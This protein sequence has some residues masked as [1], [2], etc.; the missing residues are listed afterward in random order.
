MSIISLL[1][2]VRNNEVV[3]PAIQ[4]DFVWEKPKIQKLLDSIFRGYPVGIALLWET[5]HELQYR[6]F[7][8]NYRSETLATFKDN[9]AGKRIRVV[10]DGQQRLQSLF[11][12]LFG[13]FDGEELWFDMLSGRS[14][15]DVSESKFLF[16][17]CSKPQAAEWNKMTEEFYTR[18]AEERDKDFL[19]WYYIKI[20][21]LYAMS[22]QA[23]EKL[24]SKTIKD[25]PLEEDDQTRSR[26]NLAT[27][28]QMLTK[29]ENVL[30]L[31]IID[32]NL[33]PESPDRKTE[34][35]VLEIF[36]RINREGT[37]LNRAD[38]IF[39]MLKLNWKESAE[40]LPEFVLKI[41][42]GNSLGLNADFV[43]RC[44]FAVSDLGAKFDL[45]LLRKKANVQK[46]RENFE[47]C[48]NAIRVT[49]DFLTEHCWIHNSELLGGRAALVPFVYYFFYQ[50]KHRITNAEIPRA[51]RALYFFGFSRAFSRYG[52]SRAGAFIRDELKPRVTA[53]DSTFPVEQA[54]GWVA[55]WEGLPFGEG[56]LQR[57]PL[58]TLHLIQ[59]R[60]GASVQFDG[61][62]PETD[63]I[64]PR[65]ILR[66]KGHD[67]SAINHFANYW[68]LAREKN[69]NKSDRPPS[70]YF[71]D[72]PDAEM[73]RALIDRDML[74]FRRYSTFIKSRAEKI[75][76]KVAEKLDIVVD[77]N[78]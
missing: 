28:E 36:V 31:S 62:L 72:V 43:I 2:Q 73:K 57:N 64:F 55:H 53:G 47:K 13:S 26:V 18:P 6:Q 67:E 45:D 61:N 4:R 76:Q 1:N 5:Y 20:S 56:L 40:A 46:L 10:L 66:S 70:E 37:A 42:K 12:A 58:L 8:Q 34:T 78:T 52:D 25:L 39:S 27:F 54:A 24:I 23:R 14:Q 44:L 29:D 49:V 63:H 9:P 48:C 41:N 69:R 50:E 77:A 51:R 19:P 22:A 75:V 21:D 7:V 17:F 3:L 11:I 68:I 60:T 32:E 71:A 74:D 35:D 16:E 65:S 15:D 33:P 38:L 30:K 59:N